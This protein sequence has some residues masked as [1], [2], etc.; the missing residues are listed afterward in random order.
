LHLAGRCQPNGNN[1]LI[2]RRLGKFKSPAFGGAFVFLPHPLPPLHFMERGTKRGK[3]S[4][5]STPL[6]P[7]DFFIITNSTQL[8]G[9][10][11]KKNVAFFSKTIIIILFLGFY[12]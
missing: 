10:E 3:F 9:E 5:L 7:Q 4:I 11:A 2:Y 12:Y 6:T 1:F 8:N